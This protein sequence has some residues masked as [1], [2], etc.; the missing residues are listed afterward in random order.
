MPSMA[1]GT[2]TDSSHQCVGSPPYHSGLVHVMR[3]LCETCVFRPGNLMQLDRGRVAD[4]VK[5]AKTNESAIICHM[6]IYG[7]SEQEAVCRGYF[8]RY[9]DEVVTL[10]LAKIVG[11]IKEM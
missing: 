9:G 11:I 2:S 3:E 8:D 1:S 7:Q 10:R 4:M 6:T 5:Q